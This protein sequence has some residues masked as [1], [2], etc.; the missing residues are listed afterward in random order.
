[1]AS[2]GATGFKPLVVG[3]PRSGFALLASVIAHFMPLAQGRWSIRQEV[4]NALVE[5]LDGVV[6]EGVVRAF[7]ARGVTSDLLYNPNFRKLTG[8]PKWLREDRRELACFRKYIGVRH[9]GDFTLVTSHPREV[10]DS[11]AVVHSHVDPGLWLSDP[12]YADYCPFA[13][14]R[15][16]VGILNSSVFSINALASEYIQ[17]FVP[18]E[19]DN[20]LLRQRLA[21]YKLTDLAFVR[22]L[23]KFLVGYLE[24]FV[25]HWRRYHVMRWESLL[26]L[27]EA[28]ILQLAGAAGI[29]LSEAQ[30]AAIWAR[31]DHVNL[32]GH[33]RHNYRAGK[34]IV[35]DWRRWLVNE[36]FQLFEEMGLEPLMVELGYGR[37]PRLKEAE[38]TDF[39]VKVRDHLKRGQICQETEDADLFTFAFNKSNIV[40]D[41]FPFRRRPWRQ[42]T[43]IERSI[44]T[45]EALEDEIW[46]VAEELTGRVN[47]VL[48]DF[49]GREHRTTGDLL[50]TLTDLETA[51]RDLFARAP[52]RTEA[53]FERARATLRRADAAGRRS[54]Q[55]QAVAYYPQPM[56]IESVGAHNI[57]AFGETYYG[58]PQALGPMEID[59]WG[60]VPEGV[61]RRPTLTAVAD[62][63]SALGPL[64]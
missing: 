45:D 51:H 21:S 9:R 14:L 44:F 40:S 62:A 46:D 3:A 27:P 15:N 22:G 8:G 20:D 10:L 16:P 48:L 32:T 24:D 39:Q 33:H 49:L 30:A 18:A 31:L 38:Y 12:G 11:D 2:N 41:A 60:E 63:L 7:E 17:K 50:A 36:H 53:A 6:A 61:I 26:L 54:A 29:K 19:A 4:F 28:T 13:S 64:A 57:V 59:A 1:M 56:L 5:G 43:R 37:M 58:I 25:S 47:Q 35:G 23:V 34:G 55:G 42:W 52:K